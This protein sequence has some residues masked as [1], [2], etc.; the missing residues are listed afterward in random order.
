[1]AARADLKTVVS[2]DTSQFTSSMRRAGATAQT[3]MANIGR[4]V[5]SAALSIGKLGISAVGMGAALAKAAAAAAVFKG[6]RMAADLEQIA[7]SF[8]V[9]T[10]SAERGQKLLQEIRTMGAETPFEFQDL[11]EAGKVL[12]NFGI[13]ADDVVPTLKMLGDISGGNSQK[14]GQLSLVFGQIA[15]TGRLMGQDLLQL[16]NSGFNPLQV[17]SQKTGESM[18]ALKKR[19]ED[20]AISFEEVSGAF[21]SATSEGGM[22]FGM[23]ERQSKTFNGLL[24]TLS[25]NVNVL[26][27]NLGQ[28][29][30]E[31]LIPYLEKAIELSQTMKIDSAAVSEH[32]QKAAE[33][34]LMI[35]NWAYKG[36]QIVQ[37][38]GELIGTTFGTL[39]SADFWETFF[40]MGAAQLGES[41]SAMLT[42][43]Y[44]RTGNPKVWES[45]MSLPMP[46]KRCAMNQSRWQ[47]CIRTALKTFSHDRF[48]ALRTG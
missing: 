38:I 32:F 47:T 17:I 19:M 29:I 42:E 9:M 21:Q 48:K 36:F 31:G 40:N 16:I 35:G 30:L 10:Q 34:A 46:Q 13:A 43:I 3:T 14:L 2:A 27:T 37:R 12:L 6:V 7:I 1:M 11:A 25:D 39:L 20:G 24:S 45:P 26:L 4:G 23:M 18:A 41:L 8:E 33:N 44:K 15:S 22:F 28:P 5:G